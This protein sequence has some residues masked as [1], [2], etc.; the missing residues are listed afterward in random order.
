[1]PA[2]DG[3][4]A[5]LCE[6]VQG[7]LRVAA[8]LLSLKVGHAVGNGFTS[9]RGM[10]ALTTPL[11]TKSLGGG[12]DSLEAME[13]AMQGGVSEEQDMAMALDELRN[14]FRAGFRERLQAGML[15]VLHT[16]SPL[17]YR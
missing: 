13:S 4:V 14:A 5:A 16:E 12:V 10:H 8:V 11:S 2:R 3:T 6:E 15:G 1:M 9:S 7:A 17:A